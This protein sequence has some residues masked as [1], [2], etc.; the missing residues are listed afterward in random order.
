MQEVGKKAYQEL[1]KVIPSF[2]RRADPAHKHHQK[3][4]EYF[5]TMHGE[6]E[7][8]A[9]KHLPQIRRARLKWS[10]A[11]RFAIPMQWQKWPELCYLLMATPG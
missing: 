11:D 9:Q 8:F 10:Q 5:E 7:R 2:I 3:L 4:S 1:S 6:L